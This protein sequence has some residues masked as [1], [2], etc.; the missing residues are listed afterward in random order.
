ML[1][2]RALV[3]PEELNSEYACFFLCLQF[4]QMTMIILHMHASAFNQM[5]NHMQYDCMHRKFGCYVLL[6]L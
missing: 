4:I 2:A 5:N 6:Y 3:K 1:P